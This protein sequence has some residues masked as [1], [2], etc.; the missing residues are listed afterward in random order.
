MPHHGLQYLRQHVGA[1]CPFCI[2]S[3][4]L[5]TYE[6]SSWIRRGISILILTHLKHQRHQRRVSSSTNYGSTWF[7]W[8]SSAQLA[9][10][11]SCPS[12]FLEHP[13]VFWGMDRWLHHSPFQI[14][15]KSPHELSIL[16]S[17]K[18]ICSMRRG[19]VW[20]TTKG[21][22]NVTP[23]AASVFFALKTR[24]SR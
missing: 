7:I 22:M 16:I 9:S 15:A 4:A 8:I 6:S 14:P 3:V 1:S 12:S 17:W 23:K 2:Y 21:I 10:C 11:S 24:Y 5:L 18:K 19:R 13:N 20:Y